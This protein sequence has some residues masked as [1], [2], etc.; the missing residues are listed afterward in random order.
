MLAI[1]EKQA[2]YL[3]NEISKEENVDNLCLPVIF[4]LKVRQDKQPQ[5][6]LSG[7][8]DGAK[9]DSASTLS[10]SVLDFKFLET[11]SH[12][13]ENKLVVPYNVPRLTAVV[14]LSHEPHKDQKLDESAFLIAFK[15]D[16]TTLYKFMPANLNLKP[17]EMDGQNLYEVQLDYRIDLS[18]VRKEIIGA[19]QLTLQ[20]EIDAKKIHSKAD[21]TE[22]VIIEGA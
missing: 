21:G 1:E 13:R 17:L 22:F 14:L 15:A 6:G 5:N 3:F 19:E 20:L 8:H 4:K 10:P 18:S 16:E 7:Q 9:T 11:E 12:A 2:F